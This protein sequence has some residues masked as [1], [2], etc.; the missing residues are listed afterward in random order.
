MNPRTRT[1]GDRHRSL[2]ARVVTGAMTLAAA[3]A[4][5]IVPPP[6]AEAAAERVVVSPDVK[7]VRHL[8]VDPLD[9]T[10]RLVAG[11]PGLRAEAV[12]AACA[13]LAMSS[14]PA[15][16]PSLAGPA[17]GRFVESKEFRGFSHIPEM[18]LTCRDGRVSTAGRRAPDGTFGV[19]PGWTYVSRW[20]KRVAEKAEWFGEDRWFKPDP[21]EEE[22]RRLADGSGVVVSLRQ[23]S[24]IA[25]L[26]RV[27]QYGALGHDAPF[28]WSAAHVHLRCDGTVRV[29]YGGST[30]PGARLYL[31]DRAVSSIVQDD[32]LARF[33]RAGGRISHRPGRGDLYDRCE[34]REVDARTGSDER[35][36]SSCDQ[37]KDDAGIIG[38]RTA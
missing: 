38:R 2:S 15:P 7:V 4:A 24:R 26:A 28:I 36:L 6:V 1:S 20:G 25:V 31:A 3:A 11:L 34:A 18:Q 23:A 33:V 21:D 8:R 27:G 35:A 17:W 10:T 19:S 14:N 9:C 16:P 30:I 12:P 13:A 22:I 32:D 5:V 37:L 29:V